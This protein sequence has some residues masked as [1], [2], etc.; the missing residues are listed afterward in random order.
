MF[1]AWPTVDISK[2]F[3]W[4]KLLW[5]SKDDNRLSVRPTT[6]YF[7]DFLCNLIN[8]FWICHQSRPSAS[9]QT[10]FL[11]PITFS[12]G[13]APATCYLLIYCC[14]R[15]EFRSRNRLYR[16]K[17]LRLEICATDRPTDG[18]VLRWT[19]GSSTTGC[20]KTVP[21]KV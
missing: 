3:L 14:C 21:F 8:I 12:M 18:V 16:C 19:N 13:V 11:P 6:S 17:S 1:V 4:K 5:H 9:K 7:A 20:L 15:R 10:N 2:H